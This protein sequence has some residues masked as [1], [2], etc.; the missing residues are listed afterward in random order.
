[1]RNWFHHYVSII[2]VTQILTSLYWVKIISDYNF[3][4]NKIT[5]SLIASTY[6]PL[7]S[8]PMRP[9][10]RM[11]PVRFVIYWSLCV[12]P[13][14]TII[15]Y[16]AHIG[17]RLV[18]SSWISGADCVA[19]ISTGSNDVEIILLSGI[20]NDHLFQIHEKCIKYVFKTIKPSSIWTWTVQDGSLELRLSITRKS[21]WL[22]V[23]SNQSLVDP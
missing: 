7:Q 9:K 11:F 6:H 21:I 14:T 19:R 15:P 17:R 16:L 12:S 23:Y 2:N 22:Q 10:L 5:L 4:R 18:C 1:M 20:F 8:F 13:K 3:K